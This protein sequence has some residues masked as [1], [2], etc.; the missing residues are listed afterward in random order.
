MSP[1]RTVLGAVAVAIPLALATPAH[2]AD[3]LTA[4]VG[5]CESGSSQY[6]CRGSVSGGIAP[7][8]TRWSPAASGRC[9]PNRFLTV[10]LTATDASGATATGS[11]QVWCTTNQWP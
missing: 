2:A 1:V 10:T 11:A 9:T 3:P 6:I 4:A 8:T 5:F 7:V